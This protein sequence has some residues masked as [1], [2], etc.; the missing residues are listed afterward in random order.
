MH[1]VMALLDNGFDVIAVV[2]DPRDRTVGYCYVSQTMGETNPN[3]L[4]ISVLDI[5]KGYYSLP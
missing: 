3:N 5:G 1:C 2:P 4:V